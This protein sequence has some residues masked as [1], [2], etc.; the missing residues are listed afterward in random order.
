MNQSQATL[1][2]LLLGGL[3]GVIGFLMWATSSQAATDMRKRPTF[4]P[5]GAGGFVCGTYLGR[6]DDELL[7]QRLQ[8][9]RLQ[10][11]NLAR[12]AAKTYRAG[13][14]VVIEDNGTLITEPF[15]NP[16]D[17]N[18]K[19]LH[20]AP[21]TSGSYDITASSLAFD[22]DFGTNLNAGD[23]T[24]HRIS[25]P[26]GF[27]FPFFGKT[28]D[29]VWI[30]SN[31]NVTFG[32]IGNP[33][34][35]D[36]NDFFIDVPML[37]AFFVDLNP[38]VRGRVLYRQAADRFIVTWDNIPE[39][40]TNNSNTIQLTLFPNGTFDVV[41]NRVDVRLPINGLPGIVGVT[42][43]DPNGNYQS[44]DL[45]RLPITGSNAAAVYEAFQEL[46]YRAVSTVGIAQR[47][48]ATQPD[49]F[50]QIVLIT[51][52]DLLGAPFG[53]FY[54][55]VRNGIKGTGLPAFNNAAIYGSAGRLQGFLHMNYVNAWPDLSVNDIYLDVLGQEAEHEW[56]AFVNANI[57]GQASDL[58]LGRGLAHWSFYLETDGS[59]M[60]GNGWRDN[61][62]GTFTTIRAFDNYA[63]LDHYLIGLRPPEEIAPFF[64]VDLPG[65]TLAQRSE[66]PQVGVT[67]TAPKRPL[68]INDII[69]VE[70]PREPSA[71]TAPKVFRQGYVYLLRQ[72]TQP[73]PANL[74]KA[75][76]FRAG[77][78]DY[79]S[80]RTD[81][82]GIMQTQL[83]AE[84][85]VATVQGKVTS[86]ADGS[87]VK[88][89]TATLLEKKVA[90]PV[91]DGGNYAFR[92]LGASTTPPPM[93]ATIVLRAF[94]FV[95][96]TSVV[97]LTFGS[98]LQRNR[99]LKLLPQTT[100]TGTV[101]DLGGKGLAAKLTLFVKSSDSGDY[102]LTA[103]SDAQGN[104]TFSGL[105]ASQPPTLVYDRL[106]VEPD[107]PFA[108]K[109]AANIIINI[110]TPNVLN[111]TLEPAEVLLVNDD[112]NGN[113][114]NFYTTALDQISVTYYSWPQRERGLAPVSFGPKF[115]RNTIIWFTGNAAGANVL[116]PAERDSLASH[117]DRGGRLFL[118][119]QNI[120]ESLAGD[121]FLANRLRVSF[122]RNITDPILHG[123]QSDPVGKG[124]IAI[125]T[126]GTQG[127]GG[128]NNQTSRDL[129]QPDAMAKV[130]VL[131][132]STNATTVAGVRV[133][134]AANKSRLV[135]FGFGVEAVNPGPIPRPGFVGREAVLRNVL[136]WLSGTTAVAA[137]STTEGIPAQFRLSTSYPNPWSLGP[138]ATEAVI[139]YQLP[140]HPA[141]ERVTLKVFD[142][143]G[144]EVA[145]LVDR[146]YQPGQYEA[147][148]NGRNT[149][150]EPVGNG[151]YFYSL[152]AGQQQQVQ[153]QLLVR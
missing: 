66:G 94:P 102:A 51:D 98:T 63:L 42:K 146:A 32:G 29:H 105:Y 134:D 120:A 61:G 75:E 57:N 59:V 112:P 41:Y 14:L 115:K 124:L 127:P 25:F 2:W 79:F 53:A 19:R 101:R 140:L 149:Q 56:G 5:T 30:R 74:A 107:I 122:A 145:A 9:G 45:S 6:I 69:A 147:R 108:G 55:P 44:V 130:C 97:D 111:F 83:G 50:D 95:S 87:I 150:G 88:N 70:G 125:V 34:F 82:R 118:A 60:E 73:S 12:G 23:D 93:Q 7:H 1:R 62:N 81:G 13:N 106:V 8:A 16:V 40:D 54:Q 131:Y 38:L 138:G 31:A 142:V 86:A 76:R 77:W 58:I 17:L 36:P 123:V 109:T 133:E 84:F 11:Q 18:G 47:F 90:Q 116:T 152:Q 43:G 80:D 37:A 103:N 27:T 20:F 143:L 132:D 28:W 22:N 99:Q 92:V 52:F 153:K 104:Y 68:T 135:F 21:N 39:F 148:W 96:D 121:A 10:Q 46:T 33:D 85:P 71:A 72:G 49:S 67:V 117:L 4:Q 64:L 48:Y 137:R 136:N 15:Q 89:L 129:L 26:A 126:V 65:V 35:Y 128:A 144:R 119:G 151:V 24:N 91:Y 113:F 100:L 78:P 114:A 141:A 3:L 110:G 139:R